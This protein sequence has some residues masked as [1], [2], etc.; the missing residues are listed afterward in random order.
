MCETYVK[1][2]AIISLVHRDLNSKAI[3]LPTPTLPTQLFPEEKL[4]KA[5]P[6]QR[7]SPW[8]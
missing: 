2:R 7:T 3:F 6:H 1:R 4:L 8:A 5:A